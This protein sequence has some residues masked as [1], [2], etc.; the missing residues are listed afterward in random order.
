[1]KIETTHTELSITDPPSPDR[2]TQIVVNLQDMTVEL[3]YQGHPPLQWHDVPGS[4]D[5]ATWTPGATP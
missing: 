4:A 3:T 2:L 1:M 5:L